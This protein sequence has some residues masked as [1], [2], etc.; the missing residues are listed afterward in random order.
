MNN[1]TQFSP[2]HKTMKCILSFSLMWLVA[3]LSLLNA[4][5]RYDQLTYPELNP[6]QVPDIVTFELDN[7]ITFYLVQDTE[8]PLINLNVIVRAGS[9]M[10]TNDKAGLGSLT[11]QVMRNGGSEKY[12]GEELNEL[13]ENNAA[14]MELGMGLTSGSASMNVLK[15]DFNDLLPVFIDLL[16]NPAFPEDKLQLAKTQ[17]RSSISRRNDNAQGVANREFGRLIYGEES[18]YGRLTEYETLNN[19]EREDLIAFHQQAFTGSNLMIGI[20]GDFSPRQMRRALRRAFADYPQGT[21]NELDLPEVD[22]TFDS[23]INFIDKPDVNQSVISMGH[24]GGLRDNPDYAAL[25][26]MNQILSGGFSG[27]LFQIVRSEMG[28]AYGVFGSYQ[29]NNHYKGQFYAGISTRS[30]AT[31]EAIIAVRDQIARLQNERVG[32]AEL[33]ETKERILNSLVFRTDSKAR[34]LR[35]RMSNE[36]NGLPAD[37]FDQYIEELREVTPDDIYR[38]ANEYIQPDNMRI[39]VVGNAEEIGDQLEQ[40]GEVNEIDITIPRAPHTEAEAV[41]GDPEAGREWFARVA[42]AIIEPGTTVEEVTMEGTFIQ[43]TE[44]VPGGKMTMNT[45]ITLRPPGVWIQNIETPMGAQT[46]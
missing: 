11:T 43:M 10:L 3:G 38:V 27:R 5:T 14:R 45:T 15:E 19:I 13:L 17:A 21:P 30:E 4:Q 31:G 26:A 46:I 33:E 29:S 1:L 32:D 44:Q 24:I 22:Y 40:F 12:P 41:S 16:K 18:L 39:L 8:L 20:T 23:S 36:Y 7:G 9:F 42:D 25:Q 34:V 35:E 6:Y 28:L 37:A 2:N